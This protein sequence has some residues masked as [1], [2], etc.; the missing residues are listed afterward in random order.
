[1]TKKLLVMATPVATDWAAENPKKLEAYVRGYVAALA[2][3]YD[4]GNRD[5]SIAILRKNLPNMPAE[6]AAGCYT[7]M[8]GAKGFA[9]TAEFD[10]DG[11]RKVLELRSEYGRPQKTLTDP[12]RYYDP[13]YYETATR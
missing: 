10:A 8:I 4:A 6:L 9:R 1:M 12:A 11:V 3:L 5:E 13:Q 2:F 7:A